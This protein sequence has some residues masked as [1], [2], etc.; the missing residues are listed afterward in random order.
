MRELV[1]KLLAAT[2]RSTVLDP[3]MPHALL[4]GTMISRGVQLV[5][6][7]M[8]TGRPVLLASG[9]RFRGRRRIRL[10]RFVSLGSGCDIDGYGTR[11]TVFA[12]GS[13][14]GRGCVVTVTSHLSRLG[15]GFSLGENSG[16]GD[17]CHMGASGGIWIGSDVIMGPFVSMHSQEHVFTDSDRPIRLQGTTERGIRVGDN[18]WI[19]ARVTVLD[20]TDIGSGCVVAAGAVVKGV[21]PADSIIAGVPAKVIR[22]RVDDDEAR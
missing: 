5:R 1:S 20:G 18:C 21:F 2:G 8:R 11:G 15:V 9:V 14:L 3:D 13:R 6:G 10:G 22:A 7:F 17:Y 19:G 12:D 16:M 4:G